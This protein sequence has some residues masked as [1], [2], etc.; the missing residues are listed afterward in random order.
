MFPL[1]GLWELGDFP[2]ANA[3][4]S[5]LSF[6]KYFYC[7]LQFLVKTWQELVRRENL[8]ILREVGRWGAGS[9]RS[10]S[11]LQV[12][13]G[14]MMGRVYGRRK[15]LSLKA[16]ARGWG[17]PL[18][19]ETGFSGMLALPWIFSQ[20]LSTRVWLLLYTKYFCMTLDTSHDAFEPQFYFKRRGVV[21]V[22]VVQP[23]SHVRLFTTS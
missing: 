11:P 2:G 20:D 8:R 14:G 9:I 4:V 21:L 3:F 18:T 19:R 6:L 13:T 12:L 23:P 10:Q 7:L 1:L 16:R 22:V 17:L 15:F 5:G